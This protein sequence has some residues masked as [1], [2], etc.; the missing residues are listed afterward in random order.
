VATPF[1]LDMS[2]VPSPVPPLPS[3]EQPP[4]GNMKAEAAITASKQLLTIDAL[5]AR[6]T[7]IAKNLDAII[8]LD[9]E[10]DITVDSP[11]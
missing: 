5:F 9:S 1:A 8:E 6:S 2:T 7:P 11:R 4:S 3:P 10:T